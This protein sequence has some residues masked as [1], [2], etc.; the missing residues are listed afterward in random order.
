MPLVRTVW[1][2]STASNQPQRRGRPVTTP[3]SLPRSPMRRP[4]RSSARSGTG[5][6]RR[7]SC[8]PCDAE[9]IADRAGPEPRA[10]RRVAP[11]RCSR[12]SRTDRCRGRRRAARPARPRTECACLRAASVEQRPYR[13]HVRQHLGRHATNS[14]RMAASIGAAC[15]GPGAAH[16]DG[17]AAARSCVERVRIGEVHQPDGAPADLVLVG[18]ADAAPVVPMRSA[19]VAVSRAS[20]SRCS[21]RISGVFSAMRRFVGRDLDALFPSLAISSMSDAD[22]GRRR[23]R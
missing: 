6:R 9:H 22:R 19:G 1:R 18:R 14:A 7:A 4:T 15:R 11:P 8:R 10:G 12:T 20:S 3:N 17:R 23:C 5:R 13:I 16:C 2:T 21:G